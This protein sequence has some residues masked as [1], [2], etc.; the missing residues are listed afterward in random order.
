MLVGHRNSPVDREILM[1]SLSAASRGLVRLL[2]NAA[3]FGRFTLGGGHDGPPAKGREFRPRSRLWSEPHASDG[4]CDRLVA[5][6]QL[7]VMP[8]NPATR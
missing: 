7:T 3:F 1:G 6:Q 8:S 4:A 5:R 2:P